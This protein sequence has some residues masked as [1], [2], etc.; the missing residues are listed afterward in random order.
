MLLLWSRKRVMSVLMYVFEGRMGFLFYFPFAKIDAFPQAECREHLA[1]EISLPKRFFFFYFFYSSWWMF[2]FNE[3]VFSINVPVLSTYACPQS[4]FPWA[5][6]VCWCQGAGAATPQ[7]PVPSASV[8]G[9]GSSRARPS[10]LLPSAWGLS[11]LPHAPQ[12]GLAGTSKAVLVRCLCRAC[13]WFL[14]DCSSSFLI[15][16]DFV[17][18]RVWR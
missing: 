13:L 9:S 4:A 6:G 18:L 14:S 10:L 15:Q 2:R 11:S 8:P 17:I 5:G 12:M 3:P 16:N 7:C 1:S